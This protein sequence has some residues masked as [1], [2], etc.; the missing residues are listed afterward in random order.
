VKCFSSVGAAL[1]V[2]PDFGGVKPTMFLCGDSEQAKEE[3]AEV[4]EQLGHEPYDMGGVQSARAIEPLC[5]LWCI[6]GFLR[7][8]WTHAFKLLR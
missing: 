1:M 8:E 2:N 3:V 5:I 6:P 7:G 4:L